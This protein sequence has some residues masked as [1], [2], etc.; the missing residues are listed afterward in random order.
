MLV[1]GESSSAKENHPIASFLHSLHIFLNLAMKYD[2]TLAREKRKFE[3]WLVLF[4][5]FVLLDLGWSKNTAYVTRELIT[6]FFW[7]VSFSV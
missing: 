2:P 1:Q 6:F 4:V 7:F 3:E 5:Y